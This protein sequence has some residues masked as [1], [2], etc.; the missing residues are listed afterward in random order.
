[1]IT[2]D[3]EGFPR[4]SDASPP[5]QP[6]QIQPNYSGILKLS[7]DGQWFA[8]TLDRPQQRDLFL[9]PVWEGE[10]IN[11]TNDS[12]VE[13]TVSWSRDGQYLAYLVQNRAEREIR[14][15]DI[16]SREIVFRSDMIVASDQFAWAGR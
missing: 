3:D 7:P 1:M 10:P 15:M 14:I 13:T 9:I 16:A 12:A 6:A 8:A 4:F 11:L 5:D 2:L